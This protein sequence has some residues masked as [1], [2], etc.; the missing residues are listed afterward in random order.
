MSKLIGAK[1]A[2]LILRTAIATTVIAFSGYSALAEK[3]S[4]NHKEEQSRNALTEQSRNSEPEPRASSFFESPD[5]P[6]NI[7]EPGSRVA[8]GTRGGCANRQLPASSEKLIALVPVY[9][10]GDSQLVWGETISSRPTFWFYVPY[11]SKASGKFVLQDDTDHTIYEGAVKLAGTPGVV[12]F[13]LPS[14]ARPLE[15]GRRYHWY[16]NVYC[17]PQKPAVYVEGWVKKDALK[18]A[19]R[20]ELVKA[21]RSQRAAVYAANGFWYDAIT[22]SAEVRRSELKDFQWVA[23]L[24][25]VGLDTITSKALIYSQLPNNTKADQK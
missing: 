23:L 6:S 25:D 12:P 10:S 19:F 1:N 3:A 20:S 14:T 9:G 4:S 2:G 24:R 5:P 15:D 13:S 17:Q 22:A 18:P 7:G 11:S 16:F 8:A 21:T